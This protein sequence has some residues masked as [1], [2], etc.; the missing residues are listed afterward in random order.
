[1]KDPNCELCEAAKIT[2]WHYEDTLCWIADCEICDVPMVVW[3]SHGATPPL[4]EK[5]AMFS[6]LSE[7]ANRLVG[8]GQW[9]LDTKMRQIPTH[10][11]A[12]ARR[13]APKLSWQ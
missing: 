8:E 3:K 2:P 10:F 12:H 11:H 7:V 1:M 9:R 6:H 13:S 5:E 4:H